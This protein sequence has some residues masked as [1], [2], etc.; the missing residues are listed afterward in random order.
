M[1]AQQESTQDFA[2]AVDIGGTKA[3]FALVNNC[4]RLLSPLEKH[5][6]PF[7][8]DGAA[9]PDGLLA[10]IQP[11]VDQ[12]QRLPGRFHGIGLSLCGNIDLETGLAVL[13]P[14]LHWR[15]LPFGERVLKAFALH[16]RRKQA[17]TVAGRA[18]HRQQRPGRR[19]TAERKALQETQ[20]HE[21]DRCRDPDR[22]IRRR[23]AVATR[24]SS[25]PCS[26]STATL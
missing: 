24:S 3:A 17:A 5:Y 26:L 22:G 9:D 7:N 1:E 18:F 13:V 25:R 2:L 15:Y 14:N 19:L 12:A 16:E 20:Q 6:V 21:R 23:Q 4:G 8:G 11:Y 10:L